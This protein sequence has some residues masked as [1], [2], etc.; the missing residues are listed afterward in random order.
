MEGTILS[1][2]EAVEYGEFK[3]TRREKEVALTLKRLEV[4]AS[5]RETDR[6]ALFAACDIAQK[7]EAAAVVVSPV[8][9][10]AARR[11]LGEEGG[12]VISCVAGGTG[13]SLIAV[14]KTEAKR[15]VRQGA[16]EIRLVPCY[17][18][19][20]GGN[21]SYLKR[22]IKRVR[23]AVKKS[24]LVYSLED[25]ALGQEEIER[26]IRAA[27]EAKADAVTVRGETDLIVFAVKTGAGRI[28]VDA[29]NVENAEQLRMLM[30]AGAERATTRFPGEISKELY[31]EAEPG[32]AV[33]TVPVPE[34]GREEESDELSE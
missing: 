25:H 29:S 7:M 33:L 31:M 10:S 24:S 5:R 19:L 17:S 22:E 6:H 28:R 18:A 4:D 13:E 12:T 3:R 1:P 15:A 32:G 30:K 27:C 16:G 9:V 23:R 34:P 2:D 8:N 26:G 14:K 21:F 20:F 11:R